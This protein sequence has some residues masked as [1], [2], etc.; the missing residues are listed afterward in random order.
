MLVPSAH[1]PCWDPPG[2]MEGPKST[3]RP[4]HA[5][6][7]QKHIQIYIYISVDSHLSLMCPL[8]HLP[9]FGNGWQCEHSQ[10]TG[11]MAGLGLLDA[12]RSE[13]KGAFHE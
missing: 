10:R 6:K 2:M 9:Y 7:K 5:L 11:Y 4:L 12:L 3:W 1:R 8:F 13:S